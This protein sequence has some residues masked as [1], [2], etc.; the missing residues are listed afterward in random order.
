MTTKNENCIKYLINPT[1]FVR[2]RVR[3]RA[4][5]N[6]LDWKCSEIDELI[7]TKQRK[8]EELCEYRKSVVFEYVT[9]KEDVPVPKSA[10]KPLSPQHT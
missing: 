9:G 8:I 5:A 2:S 7:A 3:Q 4:I 1:R 10:S 6:H